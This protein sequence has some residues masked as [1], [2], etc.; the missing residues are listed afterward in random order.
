MQTVSSITPVLVVGISTLGAFLILLSRRSPNVREFWSLAAGVIKFLL[1][2]SMV[3]VIWNGGMIEYTLLTLFPG[4]EVKFRVDGLSLLF[5]STASLLWILTT[6][7][8][9]GYM[10]SLDEHAQTRYFACFAI[11]LSAAMGVAFCANLFTLFLFYEILTF[12]T[13]PLVAHKET[14]E[15]YAGGRKY[16]VYLLGTSKTFLLA[17]ILLTFTITGTLEFSRGGM[18]PP[19]ANP[20]IL[21]VIYIL[22]L[23]G[24]TKAAMM[25]FHNWLPTAMVAPTPVSALLHAVAV[26][27][28]G[29]FSI[30]RIIM[31]VFGI[32]LVQQLHL[33]IPTAF[34]VSVTILMASVLALSQDNLKL[35]LAYSTISQLSYIILGVA[36]STPS[37]LL[38]GM[39]HIANHAFSKI[40]LFFCAGAIYVATRKTNI[41]EMAGLAKRMPWTMLA[42]TIGALSLIGVPL[43]A[44]FISKWY[45]V[46]GS[47]QADAI[48]I[49]MVLLA[50]TLLNAAYFL[51]IIY[52]VYFKDP[53][54]GES[55]AQE[56]QEAP[57]VMVTPLVLTAAFTVLLG[58]FP[59]YF[60]TLA[61][62]MLP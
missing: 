40:T 58:L 49:L 2:L 35:R 4:V 23:A 54:V 19:D 22:F 47:M 36:L 60:L 5:A 18:F 59:H 56:R 9:M 33:G 13:Y 3:P 55:H 21:T 62:L 34:F 10:R 15:A 8:S 44:G 25:P 30:V 45:L 57:L 12:V 17:A 52:T 61:K 6:C 31:D 48:I 39:L 7:Y 1:V 51:P 50:S 46:V 11:S 38:G 53:P 37:G 29:V 43:T 42:F 24:L 41:S 16:I 14:P 28:V 26:V 32:D 27:K 20:L